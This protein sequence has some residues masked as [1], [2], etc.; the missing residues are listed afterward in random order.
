MD[1]R[2]L[3]IREEVKEREFEPA[4]DLASVV[5]REAPPFILNPIDFFERTHLTDNIKS[6]IIKSLMNIL[7]LRSAIVGDRDYEAVSNLIVLPSEFGG[8]KTH[9]LI[10]LYHV[11]NIIN[12]SRSKEEAYNKLSV[13]DSDIADFVSKYWSELKAKPIKVV[14]IDCKVSELAPSPVEP[15]KIAGREIKTLWGYLGYEL[16]RYELVNEADRRETAPY[17]NVLFSLLNE[18]HSLVLIDEIGRYY[19]ESGLPPTSISNFLMNLAEALSKHTARGVS[20][21]ISLPYKV[22]KEKAREPKVMKYV[23][24]EELVEAIDMVLSRP[25][26][27]IIKPVGRKD[28]AEILRKR[29]FAHRGGEYEKFVEEFIAKELGKEYPNQVRSVLDDKRFWKRIKETYPFHPEFLEVLEKLAYKLPYL[30]KTRDALRIT[31][32]VVQAIRDGLF[33]WLEN[34]INLIM[35][36]HIPLFVD[37]V[38]T[39]I[40]LRNA[41]RDYSVFRLVLGGNVVIPYTLV[42]LKK[43]SKGKMMENLLPDHL[44]TLKEED[45]KLAVKLASIIW[46]HSLVGLGL[47]INMGVYPTTEKLIY[48]VSPTEEDVKGVLERLRVLLPQLIVHGDPESA[49][50]RW[51]FANVPSIEELIEMLRKNIPDEQAK[52]YL[53]QLLEDGLKGRRGR[54]RPSRE[55]R[56]T[57][58]VFK[59]EYSKVVRKVGEVPKELKDSNEPV[60]VIFAD[61]VNKESLLELLKGRNNLVVLAPCVE[62]FDEPQPLSSEDRKGIS[63]LAYL[64]VKTCW[65]A[66]LEM[67]KYYIVTKEHIT[68][69]QLKKFASEKLGGEELAKDILELL[70]AKVS[71][72]KEYYERQAW[73]LI[74]RTYQKVYYSRFGKLQV[75]GGLTLSDRII[76]PTLENFLKDKGLIPSSFSGENLLTLIRDYMGK[77]PEKEPIEAQKLW[78]FIRTTDQANVPIIS[79]KTFKNAV[80]DLIKS[81]DY[82]VRI[83]GILLWKPIYEDKAKAEEGDD[84][85]SL[86]REVSEILSKRGE[87]WD[88]VELIYCKNAFNEWVKSVLEKIPKD[89]VLKVKR[90]K[91]DIIDLR[92]ALKTP[93]P[94]SVIKSG[95]LFYEKKKYIVDVVIDLPDEVWENKEYTG[96]LKV[97]V[98][99]LSEEITVKLNA[100]DGIEIK[101]SEFKGKSPLE[102]EFSIVTPR[103][104]D[105]EIKVEVYKGSELLETRT[106]PVSVKGEWKEY[107]VSISEE[108]EPI[109][110]GIRVVYAEA[111]KIETIS[112]LIGIAN[113]YQGRIEGFIKAKKEDEEVSLNI[114]CRDPNILR[115]LIT[116]LTSL[117]RL[118]KVEAIMSLKMYFEEGREPELKEVVGSLAHPTLF[119]FKVKERARGG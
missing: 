34:D 87:D 82:V 29:I 28:L 78:V 16:G 7:G 6:L 112:D 10:L 100:S 13:L 102:H 69:D 57:P 86:I 39:G 64:D 114:R 92:D 41:P 97:S 88:A 98:E 110:D 53:A 111:S 75:M 61:I 42:N 5:K 8:G 73:T 24:R 77:D 51:F 31:V 12:N 118:P 56:I 26:I 107:E 38:L 43:M 72:K 62:G 14:V 115:L 76:L 18:S 44:K 63:E 47:P 80:K 2:E 89:K 4:V 95:K 21:V 79:Y 70:K 46:L 19:D 15:I 20:V 96:K 45:M 91:G 105:Y 17:A 27:E 23:H 32:Q 71:N 9:S 109:E 50:A 48:S 67:V 65:D 99:G 25:H 101:P 30:Q 90:V 1:I 55:S 68:E 93:D 11:Y 84:G 119:K 33:D 83:G 49:K 74:Y 85:T 94:M 58:E 52:N 106:Q 60:A 40:L 54:G 103:A 37:E 36:Y 108:G 113:K 3:K 104:G 81:L 22:V 59:D 35:P 117:S 66:L 116:P